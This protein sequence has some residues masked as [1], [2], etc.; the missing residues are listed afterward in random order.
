MAG[1]IRTS[2]LF[3]LLLLA[4]FVIIALLYAIKNSVI[5]ST[6]DTNVINIQEESKTYEAVSVNEESLFYKI[7]GSYPQFYEGS[8]EFNKEIENL[9]TQV[10]SEFK[11]ESE[12][13]YKAMREISPGDYPS[14][15]PQTPFPFEVSFDV[16]YEG[17][18]YISVLLRAG[19]YIGGA[20]GYHN[21]YSFNFDKTNRK[22]VSLEDIFGPG[23]DFAQFLSDYTREKLISKFTELTQLQ[24]G[25]PPIDSIEFGTEP[26][27]S[28][29]NIF[30]FDSKNIYIHFPEY[31]VAAYA[32]GEQV[33]E[34]P[35]TDIQEALTGNTYR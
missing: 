33:V 19:G 8:V 34:I 16:V 28:N 31:A 20:H 22:D 7:E 5:N 17:E 6:P 15:Y 21:I 13:N 29:F 32:Y 30:T 24:G 25:I 27:A 9:I 18:D 4:T 3:F 1:K 11:D 14:E 2:L 26:V 35:K 10:I 12:G 23:T